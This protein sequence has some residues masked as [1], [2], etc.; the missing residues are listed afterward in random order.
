MATFPWEP[1]QEATPRPSTPPPAVEPASAVPP[2][3]PSLPLPALPVMH[4]AMTSGGMQ[5]KLEQDLDVSMHVKQESHD[6]ESEAAARAAQ[7]LKTAYG[8][9]AT[10]SIQALHR[11][12]P[13]KTLLQPVGQHYTQHQHPPLPQMQPHPSQSDGAGDVNGHIEWD[14]KDLDWFGETILR[15]MD[16]PSRPNSRM[17]AHDMAMAGGLVMEPLKK[18][19][20]TM[21]K[22][23]KTIMNP[24]TT[25][26]TTPA[27]L[28]EPEIPHCEELRTGQ[29]DGIDDDEDAINSD[30]DDPD[31]KSEEEEEAEVGNLSNIMLCVYE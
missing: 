21:N 5:I 14:S 31:E 23:K 22:K 8:N 26:A 28:E 4:D 27:S 30:L 16:N 20:K 3:V 24:T 17:V 12:Q 6:R 29:L 7:N 11:G 1:R 18:R 15:E 25:T 10:S 19:K 13:A 9:R 2:M